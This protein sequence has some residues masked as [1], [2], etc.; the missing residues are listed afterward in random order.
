MAD[1]AFTRHLTRFFPDLQ[2]GPV[3]G[4]TVREILD[5]LDARHPG[6][7]SYVL[8]DAGHLRKHVNIF[9]GEEPIADRAAQGDAVGADD[10]VFILQALSGG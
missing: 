3:D 4:A 9:V 7:R 8:D 6:L 10:R 2:E 1:V 5:A